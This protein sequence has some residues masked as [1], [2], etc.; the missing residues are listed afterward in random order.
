MNRY[1]P[2]IGILA[3]ALTAGAQER[4]IG[5]EPAPAGTYKFFT[6]ITKEDGAH[7]CGGALI[8]AQWVLTAA[9]CIRDQSPYYVQIGIDEYRPE[10]ISD[11]R[12]EIADVF[13][14]KDF[15]GWQPY[16]AESKNERNRGQY[17]I[18]LLKLKEPAK[19]TNFLTLDKHLREQVGEIVT[20]PG[21]GRIESGAMPDHL[22]HAD[23]PILETRRCI[24]VPEGYPDT[25]FDPALNV[26]GPDI[27]AGGDSGGPL[28]SRRNGE[29]I[30]LGLVSR[31]LIESGQFTRISFFQDWMD[32][33]MNSDKCKEFETLAK[34]IRV[35]S[36]IPAHEK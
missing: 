15:K 2:I 16:S 5:G 6:T 7:I 17:D 20:L 32:V 31:G 1:I 29:F 24:E 30:G 33:I 12:G 18:A 26:C 25:N 9:H 13:I 10:L 3:I 8:A 36:A 4:I 19:S 11:E 21:F 14:P 22:Y 23:G 28:L 35:C 27:S 34:G